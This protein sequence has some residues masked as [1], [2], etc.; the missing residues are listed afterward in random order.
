MEI[1]CRK[2]DCSHNTGA[3]CSAKSIDVDKQHGCGTYIKNELKQNLIIENG[4]LFEVS[5]EL[6][7]KNMKNVPLSCC[8]KTCLFNKNGKECTAHG[9]TVIDGAQ[10]GA[11]EGCSAVAEC[12]TYCE[13]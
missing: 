9:I 1:R 10:D 8:A 3:S 6:V 5:E 12:A 11:P 7:A 13:E 2:C 4:N